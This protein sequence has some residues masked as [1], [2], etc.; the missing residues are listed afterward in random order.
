MIANSILLP[1]EQPVNIHDIKRALITYDKVYI[2]SPDDRELLPPNIYK[3]VVFQSLGFPFL[4]FGGSYG[5]VKPLGKTDDYESD[6]ERTMHECK[7]AISQG[8]IEIFGAPKYEESFTLGGVPLPDDTPNPTLTYINY[9]QM[10]ENKEFVDLMSKGL[11]NIDFS[12]IRDIQKL[13]PTGQEDEEQ[14]VNDQKR[15]PKIKLEL[16][17]K[18]KDTNE[19]LSKMCHTRIGTL[20]KYLGYSFIKQLHPFTTDVGYANVISKLEYNFIGTVE[21]IESDE[22]LLRRQKQLS[23]LHNLILSEYIDP[24][25]LDKMDIDQILKQRT[26]AW[27]RTQESRAR[28]LTELNEIALDCDSDRKFQLVC[29]RKFKEFLKVASDYQFEV[30]KLRIMLLFDANLFF[31]LNSD[32]FQLLEKILKAPS[33]DTLLLVGSLGIQYSRQHLSTILNIIKKAEDKRQATGYAIYSNY[34]Y[35][36][37]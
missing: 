7:S 10:S 26:R 19:L 3:N 32:T 22:Q 27:G 23:A 35:L 34:R 11:L 2:T 24:E 25:R 16:T 15:P 33:F 28:L 6:F 8:K 12:K 5:P 21:S 13:S 30:D 18:E 4:P 36:M 17:D 20:V 9:R 1:T 37:T 29:N 14:S 31:F